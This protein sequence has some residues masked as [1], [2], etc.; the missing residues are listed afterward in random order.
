MHAFAF[1]VLTCMVL[2]ASSR[3][4]AWVCGFWAVVDTAFEAGQHPAFAPRLSRWIGNSFDAIPVLD[5]LGR[6]FVGGTFDVG[7]VVAGLGGAGL[8]FT[9]VVAAQ[10]M[11]AG[12]RP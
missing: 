10:R 9:A 11:R 12:A 3:C 2:H 8:A 4:A 6:Y 1:G 7:D 5:H